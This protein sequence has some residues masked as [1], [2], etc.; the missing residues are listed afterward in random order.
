MLAF[1]SHPDCLLH[2]MGKSHPECPERVRVIA[3]AVKQSKLEEHIHYYEAPLAKQKDLLRVHDQH[4]IDY[5]FDINP[6]EHIIQLDPDTWM[7]QYTLQAVLRA[8]GSVIMAVDLVMNKTCDAAFCNVRP[9]GHHAERSRA[10]GFCFFNNIAVG[11]AYALAHYELKRIAII[12]FDVHHAN[13][14]EDIFR[15]NK[16]ILLCS[17][18]QHPFYPYPELSTKQDN[19]LPVPLPAGTGSKEFRHQVQEQWLEKIHTFKPDM[20]FISAG[21]DGH[22]EDIMANLQLDDEDYGWITKKIKQ[23]ADK[24]CPGRLISV[25]EGGYALSILGQTVLQHICYLT[26][27]PQLRS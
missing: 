16:H 14:T 9:P 20:I 6:G 17:S 7:N 25:L 24:H 21:F 10:M 15:G 4:Y 13:G 2:D 18:F 1:I 22:R 26:N 19:M 5:L 8:A 23:I 3:E 11:A 12:D 27:I